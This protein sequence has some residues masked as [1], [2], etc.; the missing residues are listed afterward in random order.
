MTNQTQS[1]HETSPKQQKIH[2]TL[3]VNDQPYPVEVNP[4]EIY[5]EALEHALPPGLLVGHRIRI[6]TPDGDE[7]FPDTFIGESV[8]HFKTN[9]FHIEAIPLSKATAEAGQRTWTNWMRTIITWHITRNCAA[10]GWAMVPAPSLPI[11]PCWSATSAGHCIA[12]I[13]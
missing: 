11:S 9:T 3:V 10:N 6:S 8:A 4:Q 13:A 12:T 5:H 1:T 2:L 7:V